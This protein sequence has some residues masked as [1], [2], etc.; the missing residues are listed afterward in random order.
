MELLHK[1]ILRK[2]EKLIYAYMRCIFFLRCLI[3]RLVIY[4]FVKLYSYRTIFSLSCY[5][6]FKPRKLDIVF[7]IR[8]FK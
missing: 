1:Y 5:T 2:E 6:K 7:E 8:D 3:L 4:N